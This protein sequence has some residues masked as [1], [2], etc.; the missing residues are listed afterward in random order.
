MKTW[1]LLGS[2][3][4]LSHCKTSYQLKLTWGGAAPSD[5]LLWNGGAQTAQAAVQ[6]TFSKRFRRAEARQSQ[7]CQT[8]VQMNVDWWEGGAVM[9]SRTKRERTFF[10]EW[11]PSACTSTTPTTSW[12]PSAPSPG[13]RSGTS[14]TVTR[15]WW[16]WS[17]LSYCVPFE[18]IPSI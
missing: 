15:R 14:P 16:W 11:T 2:L 12:R 18:I 5:S 4:I 3:F 10:W 17:A 8:E 1:L 7:L 13:T 6:L 9:W